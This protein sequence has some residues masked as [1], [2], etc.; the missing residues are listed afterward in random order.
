ME[1][2]G[3]GRGK[4]TAALFCLLVVAAETKYEALCLYAGVLLGRASL[5]AWHVQRE[6]VRLCDMSCYDRKMSED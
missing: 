4:Y 2:G 1:E 3:G 6:D 5:G